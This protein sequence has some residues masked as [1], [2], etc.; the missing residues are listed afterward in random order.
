MVAVSLSQPI[1]AP[2]KITTTETTEQT[3]LVTNKRFMFFPVQ[4]LKDSKDAA[5]K[6]QERLTKLLEPV[7]ST[8][9]V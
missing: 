6:C 1:I 2:L 4:D 5:C 3:P 9:V 7:A 8:Y